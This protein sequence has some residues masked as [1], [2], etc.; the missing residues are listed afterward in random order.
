MSGVCVCEGGREGGCGRRSEFVV[1][2]CVVGG[3]GSKCEWVGFCVI[4][5]PGNIVTIVTVLQLCHK[6]RFTIFFF[7]RSSGK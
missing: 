2:V 7:V 1:C 6:K 5:L 4:L 3:K